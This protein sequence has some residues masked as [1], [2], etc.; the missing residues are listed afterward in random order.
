MKTLFNKEELREVAGRAGI[1]QTRN[2][3]QFIDNLN[4][5]GYLL[6]RGGNLYKLV[7]NWV[8]RV[9]KPKRDMYL[10]DLFI[11]SMEGNNLQNVELLVHNCYTRKTS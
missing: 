11:T 8:I 9:N 10:D 1:A 3:N 2:F 7:I 4:N 5:Q 6:N